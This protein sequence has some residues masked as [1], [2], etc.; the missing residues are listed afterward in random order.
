LNSTDGV[1]PSR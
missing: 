1:A